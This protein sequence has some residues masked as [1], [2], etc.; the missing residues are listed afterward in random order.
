MAL[1]V[2]NW[3][4]EGADIT[5]VGFTKRSGDTG[6]VTASSGG[7]AALPTNV[8]SSVQ[9]TWP[10]D[11]PPNANYSVK[12]KYTLKN[13]SKTQR[14]GVIGR[15]A[16]NT[17]DFYL[18]RAYYIAFD[19]VINLQLFKAVGGTFTQL[20]S[21]YSFSASV[22][23]TFE[24]ELDMNGSTIRALL[25]GVQ[26][27]SVTDTSHSSAGRA[28]IYN[29]ADVAGTEDSGFHIDDFTTS[30][31]AAPSG[32]TA[33]QSL[34]LAGVTNSGVGTVLVTGSSARTLGGVTNSGDATVLVTG[35]SSGTLDG[36]TNSGTFEASFPEI[37]GSFSVTLEGVANEGYAVVG[38]P[39]IVGQS[40]TSLGG[41]SSAATMVAE[42]AT[43]VVS[44]G[45]KTLSKKEIEEINRQVLNIVFEEFKKMAA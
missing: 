41:V 45:P 30:Y 4:T 20:G 13:L 38:S 26:R 15:S 24:I 37:Q 44:G 12:Q 16:V 23:M 2:S 11:L 43:T 28:G 42:D 34:T 17:R 8:T 10:T 35:V 32:I 9:Y 29:T 22:G 19:S 39:P 36:V 21:N 6:A 25:D 7:A 33:T 40:S 14:I 3:G 31:A 1:P 5:G 18:A 27:I